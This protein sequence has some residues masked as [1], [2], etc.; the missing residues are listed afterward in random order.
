MG[1]EEQFW[2]VGGGV[3]SEEQEET[4]QGTLACL[5]RFAATSCNM[6]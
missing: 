3:P 2:G 4:L 5:D 6:K 1:R